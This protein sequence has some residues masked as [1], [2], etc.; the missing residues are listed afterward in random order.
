MPGR[1]VP[2]GVP[3]PGGGVPMPGVGDIR[4]SISAATG[5][6]QKLPGATGGKAL[7]AVAI[8]EMS[9]SSVGRRAGSLVRHAATRARS[10]GPVGP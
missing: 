1:P 5:A 2:G 6:G 8:A 9:W 3:M 10:P 4:D 7:L